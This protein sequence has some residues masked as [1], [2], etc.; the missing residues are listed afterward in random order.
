MLRGGPRSPRH[1]ARAFPTAGIASPPQPRQWEMRR[2]FPMHREQ[3]NGC[4][5]LRTGICQVACATSFEGRGGRNAGLLFAGSWT[6][7]IGI[8]VCARVEASLGSFS[9][10]HALTLRPAPRPSRQ[11]VLLLAAH[12]LTHP[13][14]SA[15]SPLCHPLPLL[16]VQ[17]PARASSES[18]RSTSLPSPPSRRT[19]AHARNRNQDCRRLD[20]SRLMI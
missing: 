3:V 20:T 12:L 19:S 14:P 18:V 15:S 11:L 6:C 8:L 16:R 17:R 4:V 5:A 10:S 9:A 7:P 2:N 1:W 13:S